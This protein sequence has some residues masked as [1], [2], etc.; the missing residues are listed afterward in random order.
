LAAAIGRKTG[1]RLQTPTM[2]ESR[3]RHEVRGASSEAVSVDLAA[4]RNLMR[5]KAGDLAG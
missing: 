2:A 5:G 1:A 4:E 3:D